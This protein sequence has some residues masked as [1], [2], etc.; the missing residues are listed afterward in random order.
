M[1]VSIRIER[2]TGSS[3]QTLKSEKKG[4]TCTQA[5]PWVEASSAC[6]P[7]DVWRVTLGHVWRWWDI[8]T[9]KPVTSLTTAGAGQGT[10]RRRRGTVQ[11]SALVAE[12]LRCVEKAGESII[13][14][15]LL[16]VF[17]LNSFFLV[18]NWIDLDYFLFWCFS[19]TIVSFWL[20]NSDTTINV[21][22]ESWSS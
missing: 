18:A 6:I 1:Q 10:R 2:E 3:E 16:C 9:R 4:P 17:Y 8:G 5:M 7:C 14:L 19:Q 13:L 15:L 21:D 20:Q 22:K 11:C 12:K